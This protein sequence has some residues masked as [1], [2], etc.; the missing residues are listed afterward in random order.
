M[1]LNELNKICY[2][3][4]TYK[5]INEIII[6]D[7]MINQALENKYYYILCYA[8]KYEEKISISL[9]NNISIFLI[10]NI[11]NFDYNP[12]IDILSMND[13]N[14]FILVEALN[15]LNNNKEYYLD[16]FRRNDF[17]YKYHILMNKNI[18]DFYKT[19]IL[20][21]VEEIDLIMTKLSV[22]IEDIIEKNNIFV[23]A[24]LLKN[25]KLKEKLDLYNFLLDFKNNKLVKKLNKNK[26]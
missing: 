6:T 13:L 17:D 16:K 25:S 22:Q 9:V 12:L 18:S 11:K 2:E 1:N 3:M 24:D 7:E 4:L 10:N 5:Q 15:E 14:D 23:E 8:L 21:S 19:E 26:K 20:D